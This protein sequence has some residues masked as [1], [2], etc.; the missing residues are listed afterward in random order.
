[1]VRYS[2]GEWQFDKMKVELGI[3]FKQYKKAELVS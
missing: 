1:M 2:I 3:F